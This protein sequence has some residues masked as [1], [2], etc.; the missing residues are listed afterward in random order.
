MPFLDKLSIN[1][2]F[3]LYQDREGFMWLGT[4]GGLGRYDGYD[5]RWF[6]NNYKDPHKLT[7]NDVRCFTEDEARIWVGTVAGISLVD[8]NTFRIVPFPDPALAGREIRDLFSDRRG[9]IWAAA[10]QSVYRCDAQRGVIMEYSLTGNTNTFFEDR[11][12]GL[13]LLTWGGDILK[14]NGE[15]DSFALYARLDNTN[16]YRM[17]QDDGGR[18]WIATWGNGIWRF[19]PDASRPEDMFQPQRI[20]NPI[21]NTP[22]IVF[23]DIVQD[24]TYGYLWALSHLFRIDEQGRLVEVDINEADNINRPIDLYKTYSRI[25]KDNSG[26]LWLGA[27]DQGQ[28]V[29]FEKAEIENHTLED[30]RRRLGIDAKSIGRRE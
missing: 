3:N 1:S 27:F 19:D 8:K 6:T 14:Y 25:V 15:T 17:I 5:V 2:I 11:A 7:S 16:P 30:T 13:W 10:G 28:T 18:Y 12:G 29:T 26:T 23:Y 24:D 22:E 20:V 4:V 21:R 9:N